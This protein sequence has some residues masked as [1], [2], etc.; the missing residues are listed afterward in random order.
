MKPTPAF[1]GGLTI[2]GLTIM[3]T[4][5]RNLW[6]GARSLSWQ[7]VPGEVLSSQ[8]SSFRGGASPVFY[9]ATISYRYDVGHHARIGHRV[10]FGDSLWAGRGAPERTVERY[11]QGSKVL[12][13]V[14]PHNPQLTVLE[15]G[16][17]WQ[18]YAQVVLGVVFTWLS[19]TLLARVLH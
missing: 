19:A 7:Q 2:V 17:K 4:G 3:V 13:S 14:H 18:A 1:A 8:V 6:R 11:Q 15:P 9:S 12:V 16:I 10:F 5:I